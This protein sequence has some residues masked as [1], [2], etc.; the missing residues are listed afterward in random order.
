MRR[1]V[2]VLLVV[3]VGFLSFGA[4]LNKA[5]D[6]AALQWDGPPSIYM[7]LGGTASLESFLVGA[8]SSTVVGVGA[9]LAVSGF[10]LGYGS[11]AAA[12]VND[13]A[14]ELVDR[15]VTIFAS[16]GACRPYEFQSG[17]PPVNGALSEW[18]PYSHN[19]SSGFYRWFE[20]PYLSDYGAGPLAFGVN[21]VGPDSQLLDTNMTNCL[22]LDIPMESSTL[23]YQPGKLDFSGQAIPCH[24]QPAKPA[25]YVGQA[26]QIFHPTFG[27]LY[28]CDPVVENCG[29]L[30]GDRYEVLP[31]GC[32]LYNPTVMGIITDGCYL[33]DD[34]ELIGPY[35]SGPWDS[36]IDERGL[37][38]RFRTTAECLRP[39]NTTYERAV[40]GAWGFNRYADA[41]VVPPLDCF[42]GDIASRVWIDQDTIGRDYPHYTTRRIIETQ[43]PDVTELSPPLRECLGAGSTACV[44]TLE[45]T[46]GVEVDDPPLACEYGG[47]AAPIAWCVALE[48]TIEPFNPVVGTNVLSPPTTVPVTT[49]TTVPVT[50]P[51]T[52]PPPGTPGTPPAPPTAAGGGGAGWG[53]C[54][55][56]Q[57]EGNQ[58]TVGWDFGQL[59]T[60]VV[61]WM[62]A[63]IICAVYWLVVPP[64]GWG[65][66][67]DM[68]AG[69]FAELPVYAAF[70][71][72]I[73]SLSFDELGCQTLDFRPQIGAYRFGS[74]SI[75]VA[76]CT[77]FP[78]QLVWYFFIGLGTLGVLYSGVRSLTSLSHRVSSEPS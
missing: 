56:D 78:L 31:R 77:S 70:N 16:T 51:T 29:F 45:V 24:N 41:P 62:V 28:Y 14:A 64:G 67:W 61:R 49:P 4:Y 40:L 12:C 72:A 58:V 36:R 68:F 22:G 38:T 74:A 63:P 33:F 47:V 8:S 59:V 1:S 26:E 25:P 9:G 34:P 32:A 53:S 50:T 7:V 66:L 43:I 11:F 60:Y 21:L 5:P 42:A 52:V 17:G 39:N 65:A 55:D 75:D 10:V 19:G 73:S 18:L 76:L 27:Q 20:S 6:A 48:P 35:G 3:A 69:G 37:Q 23:G 46:P 30:P 71:D 54:M 2:S 15:V 57:L 44:G 13:T